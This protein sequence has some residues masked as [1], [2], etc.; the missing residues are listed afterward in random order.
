MTDIKLEYG[1]DSH[2]NNLLILPKDL[3]IS[4]IVVTCKANFDFNTKV[5]SRLNPFSKIP[6][7]ASY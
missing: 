7:F 5:F 3:S 6:I 1:I 4:T 2:I